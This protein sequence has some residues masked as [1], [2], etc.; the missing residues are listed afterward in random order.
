MIKVKNK[1]GFGTQNICGI[2]EAGYPKLTRGG[3]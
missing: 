1:N 3:S 2:L